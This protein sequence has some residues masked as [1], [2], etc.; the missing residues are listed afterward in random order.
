MSCESDWGPSPIGVRLEQKKTFT[1]W[2]S[3]Q[4]EQ[5]YALHYPRAERLIIEHKVAAV[6]TGIAVDIAVNNTAAAC[7]SHVTGATDLV[8]Q[9]RSKAARPAS[10][11][12][13]GRANSH[14]AAR[15]PRIGFEQRL[16]AVPAQ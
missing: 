8:D 12:S 5:H 1:D 16:Q 9:R 10:R 6:A 14:R 13:P 7:E 2:Q 15:H 4:R 3:A 11:A